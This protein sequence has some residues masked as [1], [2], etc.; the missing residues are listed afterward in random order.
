MLAKATMST[1][2][3]HIVIF[4]FGSQGSA[5]ARNLRDS[6]KRI[7]VALRPRSNHKRHATSASINLIQDLTQAAKQAEIA[8]ILLPDSAQPGFW[9]EYLEPNLPQGAA[10]VFA[11]G[12][13]IH[14]GFINPRPDLD[15]ILVAPLGQAEAVRH[16]YTKGRGVPCALAVHQDATGR[17]WDIAESY[18]RGINQQAPLIRTTF[19]EETESDLFAEQ[20]V[21]CGGLNALIRAAFDTLVEAGLNPELAYSSCLREVR[22]LANLL[23]EHGIVGTREQISDTARFGDITRGPRIIDQ[24]VRTTLKEIFQEI[25]SGEFAKEYSNEIKAGHPRLSGQLEKDK[26]HLI[27][28]IHQK[29]AG[30][31]KKQ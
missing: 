12:F 7:A 1:V 15:V 27:E 25:R 17:A 19:A 4:G 18:A 11:H 26:S 20:A 8:S 21:L 30:R 29:F 22:A 28:K 31:P 6:G 10:M 2:E 9:K 13:N 16:E 24:H 3:P 5:Q 23:Y 14:Y